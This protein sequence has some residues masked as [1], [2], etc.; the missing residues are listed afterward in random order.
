MRGTVSQSCNGRINRHGTQSS[1]VGDRG[2]LA[3]LLGAEVASQSP[4]QGEWAL[5]GA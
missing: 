4:H 1:T 2:R 3:I 5:A